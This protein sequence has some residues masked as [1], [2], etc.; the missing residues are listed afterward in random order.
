MAPPPP[1]FDPGLYG[2]LPAA[3]FDATSSSG[4]SAPPPLPSALP[5]SFAPNFS[6]T[7]GSWRRILTRVVV[8]A[9][10]I[11]LL[12]IIVRAM[13]AHQ[14]A[15]QPA[16]SESVVRLAPGAAIDVHTDGG[17]DVK[18]ELQKIQD[19]LKDL[20]AGQRIIEDALGATTKAPP[21]EPPKAQ[22]VY[23]SPRVNFADF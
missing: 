11:T 23:G 12:V 5:P 3:P 22:A 21:K 13:R 15:P 2:P 8:A 18:A 7:P 4:Y 6:S 17:G 10:V 20:S 1:A 9:V 16:C 19:A 14:A